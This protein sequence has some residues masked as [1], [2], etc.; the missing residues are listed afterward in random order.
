LL[1]FTLFFLVILKIPVA[2]LAYVI[3]WA[4]KDPPD[5]AEGFAGE[6][7][8]EGGSGGRGSDRDRRRPRLPSRRRGPHGSPPRRPVRTAY[9]RARPEEVR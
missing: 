3:W 4:V 7:L 8:P 5:P 2:Y 9:A 6:G 1:W